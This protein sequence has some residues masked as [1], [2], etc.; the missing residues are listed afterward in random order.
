MAG[1]QLVDPLTILSL[2]IPQLLEE[3]VSFLT[4]LDRTIKA[5]FSSDR[6]ECPIGAVSRKVR[7][8]IGRGT[9]ATLTREGSPATRKLGT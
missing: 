5:S 2:W 8:S 7:R 4:F 9:G 1:N 6:S 3:P